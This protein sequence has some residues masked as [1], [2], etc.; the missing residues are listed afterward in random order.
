MFGKRQTMKCP[1]CKVALD[2]NDLPETRPF[3]SPR[4][5]KLDLSNWLEEKYRLP[6]D[7]HPDELADLP[8]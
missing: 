4:C 1:M 2:P 7:L 3:C 5:K 6:R 8:Q